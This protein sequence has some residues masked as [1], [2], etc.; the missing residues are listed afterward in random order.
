MNLFNKE[1]IVE[2]AKKPGINIDAILNIPGIDDEIDRCGS[3]ED[4]LA[5]MEK[6]R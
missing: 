3:A 4:F 6:Y 2:S 1:E 5:L